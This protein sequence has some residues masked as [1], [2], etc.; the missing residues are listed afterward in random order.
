MIKIKFD[1]N[2][3]LGGGAFGQV[4]LGWIDDDKKVAVKRVLIPTTE[5]GKKCLKREED[6]LM[7]LDSNYVVKLF[8]AEDDGEFRYVGLTVM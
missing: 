6:I 4:Y 3:H 7:K 1:R 8:C 2:S 5:D